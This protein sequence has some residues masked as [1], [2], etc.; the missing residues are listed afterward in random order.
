MPAADPERCRSAQRRPP[1]TCRRRSGPEE[2]AR[3]ILQAANGILGPACDLLGPA[4]L[5][6]LLVAERLANCFLDAADDVLDGSFDAILVHDR[7]P[8]VKNAGGDTVG[9]SAPR[10]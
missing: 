4:I 5:L 3:G 8:Y 1:T 2:P 6:R 9:Y 7:N 10:R